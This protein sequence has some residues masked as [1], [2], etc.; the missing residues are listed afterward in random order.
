MENQVQMFLPVKDLV[1]NNV[2]GENSTPDKAD[3]IQ[4]TVISAHNAIVVAAW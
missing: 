1:I 3:H 4:A 2:G